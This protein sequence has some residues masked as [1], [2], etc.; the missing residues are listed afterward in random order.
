MFKMNNEKMKWVITILLP[1]V[2]LSCSVD[3]P[4]SSFLI[5]Q[6][7]NPGSTSIKNSVHMDSM[8]FRSDPLKINSIYRSMQGPYNRTAVTIKSEDK[9][10][11]LVGYNCKVFN[12]STNNQLSDDYICH[13]NL[14]YS[15]PDRYP[16]K[17]KTQGTDKRLFTITP[18]QTSIQLPVGTGIPVHTDYELEFLSQALN[19]NVPDINLE[20]VQQITIYYYSDSHAPENITPL[21]QQALFVTKQTGGPLGDFNAATSTKIKVPNLSCGVDSNSICQIQYPSQALYNPYFDDYGRTYTGH[22]NIPYGQAEW[23]TNVT[24][25]LNLTEDTKLHAVGCHVHP[26]SDS[27]ELWDLT[28]NIQIHN[29]LASSYSNK[30]GLN[31]IAY[32]TMN[33]SLQKENQFGLRSTYHCTDSIYKHSAM[34]TLFLYLEEY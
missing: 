33:I 31:H 15:L 9:L 28:K 3:E 26:Y 32:D 6:S 23:S 19:H 16:W 11:W 13:N 14:N 18:G 30:I 5:W 8:V 4:E 20:T 27:L 21:F 24:Q 29:V 12:A 1:I 10:V 7:K 22:W 25:M 2:F 34:A 17:L